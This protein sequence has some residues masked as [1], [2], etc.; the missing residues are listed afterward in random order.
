[1]AS[2][3]IG[4]IPFAGSGYRM[5]IYGRD[6]T[7]VAMGEDSPQLSEV[8]LHGAKGGNTLAPMPVP[9]RFTVA[10]PGTPSGEAINVGQMY[11]L[12]ARSIRDRAIDGQA[13]PGGKSHQPDFATAVD[14][15]RL[16]DAIKRA[17]DNGREV[18]FR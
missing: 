10:A 2:V 13:N 3:H 7:L 12:F 6:G 5:E 1:V 15:H 18:T 16:V 17:S 11:T 4:A 9:A 8:F 14:L